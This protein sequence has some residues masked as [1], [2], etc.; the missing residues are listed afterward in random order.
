MEGQK[1]L[2]GEKILILADHRE[3][4]SNVTRHLREY[5]AEI[6]EIQL[7][8]WDYII[9]E[10]V[11]IERKSIPDFLQSV[12]D[13]RLFRQMEEL[14]CSYEKPVLILEGNPE[15]LFL[16]RNMHENTIRGVLSSVA[17]DYRIPIIW[18]GNSRETASQIFWM[19][20]REQVQEKRGIQIRC[21][22]RNHSLSSQQEFLVAGLPNVSNVLSKRL[23]KHFGSVRDVYDATPEELMQ[24]EGIG[25]EKAKRIWEVI[26]AVY[27]G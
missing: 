15:M 22:K 10:R 13:Q 16:E 24:V 21:N 17:I 19:A 25:K 5:N 9:S 6:R 20:Y 14:V 26:N 1:V 18:T 7:K 23:L 27:E 11:A 2:K 8:T 3:I 4:A 12:I